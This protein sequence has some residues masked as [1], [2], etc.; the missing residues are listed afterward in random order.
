MPQPENIFLAEAGEHEGGGDDEQDTQLGPDP[1]SEPW[2]KAEAC[3]RMV[4]GDYGFARRW[5]PSKRIRECV[6]TFPYSAPEVI[7]RESYTG[8]EIDVWSL[9][10]GTALLSH[11]SLPGMFDLSDGLHLI[12]QC[13]SPC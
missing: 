6:G 11:R 12:A 8:P 3:F 1:G 7:R 5:D 13:C 4:L 10:V 2:R 9:G